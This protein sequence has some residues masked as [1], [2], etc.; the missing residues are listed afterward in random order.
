MTE[1]IKAG[2]CGDLNHEAQ[3]C[4]GRIIRLYKSKGKDFYLTCVRD[5]NHMGGN[6]HQIGDAFDFHYDPDV[7]KNEIRREAGT[8][9]D[10]VF[11]STHIHI[12]W[13]PK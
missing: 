11:H 4:K 6:F 13:D 2:V 9:F 5:G 10:L 8:G 7:T 3:K 12:E 1:W